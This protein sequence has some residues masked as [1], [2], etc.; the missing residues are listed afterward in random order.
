MDPF[1]RQPPRSHPPG[2]TFW[3]RLLYGLAVI[4]IWAAALYEL[5]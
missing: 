3:D 2:R 5:I 4:L 1:D